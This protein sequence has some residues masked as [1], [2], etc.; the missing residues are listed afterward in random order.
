VEI[1]GI[2]GLFGRDWQT[3][4]GGGDGCILG[5]PCPATAAELIETHV[6]PGGILEA[7]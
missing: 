2:D 1:N 6:R 4:G 5:K 3:G 7:E